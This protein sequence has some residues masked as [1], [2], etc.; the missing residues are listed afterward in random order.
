MSSKD[1]KKAK[2]KSDRKR[3]VQQKKE[4]AETR[5]I[6]HRKLYQPPRESFTS[7]E[8][9]DELEFELE[10]AFLDVDLYSIEAECVF[11]LI[12]YVKHRD[13]FSEAQCEQLID[14]A[15]TS[16]GPKE[17]M[18]HLNG[19]NDP[20][21][22][23]QFYSYAS[24]TEDDE[25]AYLELQQKALSAD[26][27]NLLANIHALID[28]KASPALVE[29]MEK[30]LLRELERFGPWL[31]ELDEYGHER[32]LVS[33]STRLMIHLANIH[34]QLKQFEDSIRYLRQT[35]TL[36]PKKQYLRRLRLISILLELGRLDEARIEIELHQ[37]ELGTGLNLP[38]G[39][40]LE[41]YLRG[42][43]QK[44]NVTLDKAIKYNSAFMVELLEHEEIRKNPDYLENPLANLGII[45]V[46]LL[47]NAWKSYPGAADWLCERLDLSARTK[48]NTNARLPKKRCGL[49]GKAQ[50][51]TRTP[52]C[53]QWICDDE[54]QYEIFS[55]ARNSCFRNHSRYTLCGTHFHSDHRGDWQNCIKCKEEMETEMYV[56]SGTNHYNFEF[57]KELPA[58]Q[59]TPC[60]QCQRLMDLAR[61]GSTH[62]PDGTILCIECQP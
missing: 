7:S 36:E 12:E 4:D 34:Y 44:A 30:L 16:G 41:S 60:S 9:D 32:S 45:G 20:W 24:M 35:L 46:E 54:D 14:F 5:L 15:C 11:S 27:T 26:P 1:R 17:V 57:L 39:V 25:Q 33:S 10:Q 37:D 3:K 51:L 56:Y 62:N 29:K 42:D 13:Q 43:M 38:Y 8:V 2:K 18:D 31:Y 21:M 23:A 59:R 49:C 6:L 48:E 40:A 55:Y 19:W 58:F 22:Q 53:D 52:C 50:K 28:E 61:E 47:G